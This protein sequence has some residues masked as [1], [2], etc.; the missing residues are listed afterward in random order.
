VIFGVITLFYLTDWPLQATWLPKEECDWITAELEAEKADKLK[1]RSYTIPQ[2]LRQR[3]VILLTL[4]Y[5]MGSTAIYGFIIWFPTILKRAS[6]LSTQTV[7]LLVVL[8]YVATLIGML[9]NGWHS[10][11]HKERRWHTASMLFAGG[12]FLVLI[13]LTPGHLWLQFGFFV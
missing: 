13:L 4:T 9:V 3:D 6:G 7:T 1:V 2:A 12:F 11:R 10:D 8:P 5:F